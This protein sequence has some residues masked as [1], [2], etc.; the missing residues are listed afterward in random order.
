[1]SAG[2]CADAVV[3]GFSAYFRTM[4]EYINMLKMKDFTKTAMSE[5]KRLTKA[6]LIVID[7]SFCRTDSR[8]ATGRP[9]L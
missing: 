4:K 1:M 2:L 5:Y 7:V 9:S 3:K 6:N 8:L